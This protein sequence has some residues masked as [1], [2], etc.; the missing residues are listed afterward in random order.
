MDGV[1]LNAKVNG[2]SVLC[3]KR[4]FK[5]TFAKFKIYMIYF[6]LLNSLEL[7]L[8]IMLILFE[9]S[10]LYIIIKKLMS[11]IIAYY[12]NYIFAKLIRKIKSFFFF[13]IAIKQLGHV[14]QRDHSF[15]RST[16]K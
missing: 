2:Y 3:I 11:I 14:F 15:T 8:S 10:D 7:K 9:F 6:C 16:S 1:F 5:I 12:R 4:I 13:I